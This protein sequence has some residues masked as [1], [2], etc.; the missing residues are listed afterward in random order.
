MKRIVIVGG[1]AA[2]FFAAITCAEA[3]AQAGTAAEVTILEAGRAFL[4]KVRLSGGGRCNV[5]HA[6]T[7]A[8]ELAAHYPRGGRALIGPFTRFGPREAAAWFAAR[9]VPLKTEPDGRMFPTTDFSSTVVDALLRAASEAGVTLRL[10]SA[11]E[12]VERAPGG[13]FFLTLADGAAL[14]CDRLLLATGG[15]RGGGGAALAHALGHTVEPPVPSLFTFRVEAAWL[16]AL[17]G[18]SVDPVEVSVPGTP[19][20]ERGP[21]LATHWGVSGP[22]ILRLSAWGARL[23]HE[24]GY[25]FPLH[26]QWLPGKTREAIAAELRDKAA[27]RPAEAI[28]KTP[29]GALPL[30]LWQALLA[31]AGVAPETRRG[32][33]PREAR[34][35]LAAQ[36]ARTE[37]EVTGKSPHKAEFV[38][39]GG[40][41]LA[42]VDFKTQESR[43][44]PGLFFAGELLDIDGLTGGFNFQAAWTTGWSAGRAMAQGD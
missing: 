40:V 35:R 28:G 27:E 24:R 6:C 38:T 43:I 34:E 1:G 25:R 32:A 30:R 23:L 21:L 39:C 33:L 15:C 22:A 42:E 4:E 18:L 36:L 29:P 8:R 37:L 19:L 13:G 3:C 9:G 20:R 10:H 12:R 5:T 44:I 14:A 7:D 11:V 2:G 16:R 31:A 41:R 17:A 26:V